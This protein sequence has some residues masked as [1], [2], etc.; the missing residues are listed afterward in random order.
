MKDLIDNVR[1]KVGETGATCANYA[2]G[3][4]INHRQARIST[5]DQA[6]EIP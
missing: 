3:L 4:N 1:K 6:R 2:V 5:A